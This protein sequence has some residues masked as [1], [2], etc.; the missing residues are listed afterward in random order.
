MQTVPPD[1]AAHQ[2]EL[3]EGV[4]YGFFSKDDH[5]SCTA[6][7]PAGSQVE[8]APSQ[9]EVTSMPERLSFHAAEA[10][11]YEVSCVASR[12]VKVNVSETD[13]GYQRSYGLFLALGPMLVCGIPLLL[14]G[15]ATLMWHW[16]R[17]RK[18]QSEMLAAQAALQWSAPGAMAPGAAT[19]GWTPGPA[20]PGSA[21]S[22]A[23]TPPGTPA[24]I[25]GTPSSVYGV[26]PVQAPG[27]PPSDAG[28]GAQSSPSSLQSP[29]HQL[30]Q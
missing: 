27:I 7:D 12:P 19:G 17:L 2:V 15:F 16:F 6:V 21:G 18:E 8:V 9:G 13:P 26:A 1:G 22:A 11:T 4:Y 5:P 25:A 29:Y 30:H 24:P 10:G 28:W 23:T 20:W 3:E 14:G